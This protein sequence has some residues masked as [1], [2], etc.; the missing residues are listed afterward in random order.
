MSKT[1]KENQLTFIYTGNSM[2]PTLKKGDLIVLEAEQGRPIRRGDVIVF[3]P[4][5]EEARHIVHRVE[6]VTRE[7]VVTRGDHCGT[8][9]PLLVRSEWVRGRVKHIVRENLVLP[10]P[11]GLFCIG[12]ARLLTHLAG[13]ARTMRNFLRPVYHQLSRS[14]MPR[15]LLF[16]L[17]KPSVLCLC[18]P[19]GREW[20]LF[21]G[22][23]EIGYL[24]PGASSWRI[25]RPYLLMVDESA[26][27]AGRERTDIR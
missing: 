7:G 21:A 23:R 12:R 27:P 11:R 18:R 25:R 9:D 17:I 16:P 8:S 1:V 15:R 19:E 14:W 22:K 10:I 3:S 20:K 6:V 13:P 26:L 5:G 24:P 4:P 2:F